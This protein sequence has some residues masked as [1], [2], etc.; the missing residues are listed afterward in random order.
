M[1][2]S[3]TTPPPGLAPSSVELACSQSGLTFTLLTRKS[4]NHLMAPTIAAKPC[5]SINS[6]IDQANENNSFRT[7]GKWKI[8][9]LSWKPKQLRNQLILSK[10]KM[11]TNVYN[12]C[13]NCMMSTSL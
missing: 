2:S 6:R 9:G 8:R 3:E 11:V 5:V 7:E 13:G 12:I 10:L 4:A 1:T